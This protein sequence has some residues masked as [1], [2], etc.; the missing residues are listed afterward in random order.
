MPFGI[1]GMS[2]SSATTMQPGASQPDC[3]T[4]FKADSARLLP[5]GGSAKTKSNGSLVQRPRQV[6]SC[7]MSSVLSAALARPML[8][9]MTL[10]AIELESTKQAK[11]DPRESASRPNDPV[12]AK[13]S[14]TLAP[15]T[16]SPCLPWVKRSN[17]RV[18][19]RIDVGRSLVS[20]PFA[21]TGDNFSPL[22][23]PA[24]ILIQC[25]AGQYLSPE[26]GLQVGG[27][28]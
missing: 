24:T 19:V 15:D 9:L 6:A 17:M 4:Q 20:D 5:Y 11:D 21:P 28:V 3:R 23:L 10:Q 2:E 14:R 13:R 18:R 8:L 22:N 27:R 7:R 16:R 26:K 12:P 25:R 1:D